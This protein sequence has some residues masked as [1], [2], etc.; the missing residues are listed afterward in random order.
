[1]PLIIRCN[2]GIV[3]DKYLEIIG[4]VLSI[5]Y[6]NAL[7]SNKIED[8]F[9]ESKNETIVVA[10]VIDA[11]KVLIK[12]Y[13]NVIVWFQGVEPEESF[14][15]H[16]NKFRFI[17]LSLM[18]KYILGKAKFCLFVSE[19]MKKHYEN[20][21]KISIGSEKYYCMPCMNTQIH[22]EA[23]LLS[24]KYKNNYFAYIGSL[25]V[26]QKFE[27]TVKAYKK[28]EEAS[29]K[30]CKLFVFTSQKEE[31]L[32]ILK[33]YKVSSYFIDYVENDELP[34]V[35]S[36]VKYGFIIR[37][38]TTVNKVATPTKIST[39]LSC[40]LIPIYSECLKDFDT[41][42]RKLEYV[43]KYNDQFVEKIKYFDEVNIKSESVYLEYKK[44]FDT[45]YNSEL[46]K[47]KLI[48][49]L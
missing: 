2:N 33:K 32:E 4:D 12:G 19:E 41:I 15:N 27:E 42:A 11:F 48:K 25:A 24:Q 28:V 26:W 34:T 10:R 30:N 38:D 13:K 22:R 9:R 8:V 43:V 14:M 47:E 40:G 44:I 45:Y 7:Y 16:K 3:T 49:L 6:G 39:Y 1:M 29:V 18:E 21:Y 36:K 31:A 20:K 46:H 5:K 35:L 17:L 23:F 37:E